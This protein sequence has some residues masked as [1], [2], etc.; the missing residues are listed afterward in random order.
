MPGGPSY[1]NDG[2][3]VDRATCHWTRTSSL[4]GGGGD[5]AHTATVTTVPDDE[6]VGSSSDQETAAARVG[7]LRALHSRLPVGGLL[8]GWNA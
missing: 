2:I 3:D 4:S 5:D 6:D 8:S 7:D 1:T